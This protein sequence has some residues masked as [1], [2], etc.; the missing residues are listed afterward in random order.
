MNYL[1][2]GDKENALKTFDKAIE[3]DPKHADFYVMRG[4]IKFF[5]EPK[6]AKGAIKISIKF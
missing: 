2:V 5:S 6:D 4:K 3:S 1:E